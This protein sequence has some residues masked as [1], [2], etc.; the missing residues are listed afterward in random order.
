[1]SYLKPFPRIIH[2]G[3]NDKSR[4]V[5]P[6]DPER[7]PQHLPIAFLLTEKAEEV[8]IASGSY[9]TERYGSAM[10]DSTSPF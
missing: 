10:M 3:I 4:R 9:L 2:H 6:L 1:M 7:L 5:I 8:Q